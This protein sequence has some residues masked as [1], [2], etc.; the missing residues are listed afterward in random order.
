[1]SGPDP[2]PVL[3]ALVKA[4]AAP[5]PQTGTREPIYFMELGG[6][7]EIQ[8]H[9]LGDDVPD[10]DKT[11]LEE[12]HGQGLLLV[13]Y[14]DHTMKIVPTPEGR[15]VAEQYERAQSEHPLA[16]L[17]PFLQALATQAGTDNPLA[18]PAVRP[19][20]VALRDYWAAGGFPVHGIQLRP[21]LTAAPEE[22]VGLF[23]ATIRSLIAGDY[24]RATS[25][26]GLN[27]L[28]SE[29]E[30]TDRARA[31]LDGW[32]GAAP[33]ELV[34]NLLAVIA[35]RAHSETDPVRKSRLE[36]VGATIKELGVSTASEVISKVITGGM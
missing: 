8:H 25:Q 35:E 12:L 32:P 10:F 26:L 23:T 3:A 34:V 29:A 18:W 4:H 19:V 36:A 1:M 7:S 2:L 33:D 27:D 9:A 14:H 30:L 31:I 28:P 20:L 17:G 11:V 22:H 24:L 15:R 13:E 6:G 16:D 21:L 5:L